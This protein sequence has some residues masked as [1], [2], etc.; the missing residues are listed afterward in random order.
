LNKE[1][2]Y[3]KELLDTM[4][5]KEQSVLQRSPVPIKDENYDAPRLLLLEFN[6]TLADIRIKLQSATLYL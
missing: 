5:K 1:L 4:G 2:S 6:T 3:L